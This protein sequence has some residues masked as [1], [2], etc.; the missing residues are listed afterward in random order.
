MR[1]VTQELKSYESLNKKFDALNDKYKELLSS[2]KR[3]ERDYR[4]TKKKHEQV[5]KEKDTAKTD[6]QKM[7]ASK[8]KL[9]TV[10]QG[11][12]K[13]IKELQVRPRINIAMNCSLCSLRDRSSVSVITR[14]RSARNY[15]FAWMT[16]FKLWKRPSTQLNMRN[17]IAK[18]LKPM[19]CMNA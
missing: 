19:S 9:E 14:R 18:L 12:T 7:T 16:W 2:M 13:K 11:L 1:E 17:R 5:Q 15:N 4:V 3:L 8:S 6:L 10:S